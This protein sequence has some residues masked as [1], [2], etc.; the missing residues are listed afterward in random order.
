MKVHT[1]N[2]FNSFIEIALSSDVEKAEIPFFNGEDKT[3]A[4]MQFELISLYPYKYTSDELLFHIFAV[5]NSIAESNLEESKLKFFS[6]GQ[7]CLRS[8]PLSKRYGWG[9]HFNEDGKVA[10]YAFD[11]EEYQKYKND[12][13]LQHIKAM[14]SKRLK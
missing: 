3:I 13:N 9:I 12:N 1:T 10:I 6:K 2:Y 5:R 4:Y 8:S 14:N 11:S 7:P